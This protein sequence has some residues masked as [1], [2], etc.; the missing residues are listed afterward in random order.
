MTFD[1]KSL[2]NTLPFFNDNKFNTWKDILI[3]FLQSL[4]HDLWKTIVNCPI[5]PTH[6]A[7]NEAVENPTPFGQK[8]KRDR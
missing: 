2:L 6:Q 7:N 4:N 5:Y 8:K 3:I 1:K